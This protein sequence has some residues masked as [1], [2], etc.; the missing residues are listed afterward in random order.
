MNCKENIF[1]RCAPETMAVFWNFI[2]WEKV[3]QH[4]KSLQQ[5]IAKAISRNCRAGQQR[6]LP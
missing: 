6:A 2:N 1:E 5:R 4:V 3:K